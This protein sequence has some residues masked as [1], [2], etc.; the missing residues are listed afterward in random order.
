MYFHFDV[1]V[2]DDGS[3]LRI[4]LVLK[5]EFVYSIYYS[6][7][8]WI[9]GLYVIF[10]IE[11]CLECSIKSYESFQRLREREGEREYSCYNQFMRLV[12]YVDIVLLLAH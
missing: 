11:I 5:L 9:M 7:L 8:Q 1:F 4:V 6:I 2:M 10:P 3:F 12:I